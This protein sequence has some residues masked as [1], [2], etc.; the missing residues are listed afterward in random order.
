MPRQANITIIDTLVTA[1]AAESLEPSTDKGL[2]MEYPEFVPAPQLHHIELV[3]ICE[4]GPRSWVPA[5]S[6]PRIAR[7]RHYFCPTLIIQYPEQVPAVKLHTFEIVPALM[8]DEA[9]FRPTIDDF[10]QPTL[11]SL[12]SELRKKDL[13]QERQLRKQRVAALRARWAD[14]PFT[15]PAWLDK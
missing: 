12:V 5:S 15:G 7:A 11:C 4:H 8:D 1:T 9:V 10:L 2:I 3:D 6:Q 14:R 13:P